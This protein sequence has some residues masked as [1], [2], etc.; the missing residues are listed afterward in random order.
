LAGD[1]AGLA[2]DI[3]RQQQLRTLITT[4]IAAI[5]ASA[6]D[7][8]AKTQALKALRKARQATTDEINRLVQTDK[9]QRAAQR[10][11]TA[12]A[13]ASARLELAQTTFDLTG[14]KAPLERALDAEIKRQIRIKNAAKKGSVAFIQAQTEIRRLL[15]QKKDL[16]EEVAKDAA[17]DS[18]T[19]GTS[20][21][22]LFNKAQDILGGAGNVGFNATSLAGLSARPRIQAEVQ[23]RLDIVNDPAKAAAAKQVASTDRLIIA[24]DQLTQ[25]LTGNTASGTPIT[26]REQNTWRNLTQEQRFYNQRTARQMV[27]Q[28]LVG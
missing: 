13:L 6:L 2:D 23:Q 16:N 9:E 11:Q 8:E 12:E 1:T 4:Q 5:K 14:A 19:D 17:D 27:E 20:L 28:G 25:T 21:V 18:A 10:Q 24:I 22:D 26:R 3:S 7:E 15:K